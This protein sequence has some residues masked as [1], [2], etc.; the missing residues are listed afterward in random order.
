VILWWNL[1]FLFVTSTALMSHTRRTRIRG[2]SLLPPSPEIKLCGLSLRANDTERPS[3]VSEVN[4]NLHGRNTDFP[5]RSRYCFLQVAP[6]LYLRG[7]VDP[8]PD[9]LLVSKSGSAENRTRTSESAGICSHWDHGDLT[10]PQTRAVV[11]YL[12]RKLLPS[13]ALLHWLVLFIAL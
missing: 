4:A 8:V 6:Q 7:W 11:E 1:P 13:C 9:P 12:T 5:D 3:L 2:R 10:F